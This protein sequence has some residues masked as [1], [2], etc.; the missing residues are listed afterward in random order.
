M[1]KA[2]VVEKKRDLKEMLM[3]IIGD[4]VCNTTTKIS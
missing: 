1:A 4:E 2:V 3:A